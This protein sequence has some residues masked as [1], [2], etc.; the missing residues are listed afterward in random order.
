MGTRQVDVNMV[1]GLSVIQARLVAIDPGVSLSDAGYDS[2]RTTYILVLTG[3]GREGRARVPR[4]LLDDIRDNRTSAGSK[5][6]QELHARLSASL[7]EVVESNGLISFS[8]KA[9]KYNLLRFIYN[10]SKNGQHIEKYN[11]IGR[12]GQGDFERWLKIDLTPEEKETLIWIWGD[13]LRLRLITPTGTDLVIPD[14]WVRVT[15]KGI[16]AIEGKAYVEY[17]E[18]EVFIP[19]GEVYTAYRTIMGIMSEARSEILVI[20][21]Y[22]NEDLLDMFASLDASV[23]IRVLTEHLKGNFKAAFRKLQQQRGGIEVRCSSQFHDRF[24][25]VDGRSCHQLGGSINHAGAKATVIG[26]KSDAI[27]DRVVAEAATA[28]SLAAPVV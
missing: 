10:E 23:S 3:Q 19:K 13:L 5:Y 11:T 21:P 22:V 12:D 27:R 7:R 16:A 26:V 9:L 24:I 25:V 20:D 18:H 15:D 14:N 1:P 2:D 4:E 8:E 28:W 6:T 17:D